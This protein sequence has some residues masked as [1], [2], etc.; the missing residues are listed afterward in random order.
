MDPSPNQTVPDLPAGRP[1]AWAAP[2][3]S[4]PVWDA[5]IAERGGRLPGQPEPPRDAS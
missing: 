4:L 2:H 5:L 3:V 1:A